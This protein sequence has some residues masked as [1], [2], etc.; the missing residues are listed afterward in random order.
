M[1]KFLE[2]GGYALM[3]LGGLYGLGL[4]VAPKT[5]TK[6]DDKIVAVLGK[7]KDFLAGLLGKK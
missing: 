7:V 2:I 5:K 3:V 1:E 4:V 6:I